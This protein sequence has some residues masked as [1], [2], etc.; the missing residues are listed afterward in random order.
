MVYETLL[1]KKLGFKIIHFIKIFQNDMH[2][3]KPIFKLKNFSWITPSQARVL[4]ANTSLI[5]HYRKLSN[6]E[7][8]GHKNPRFSQI[9]LDNF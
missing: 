8:N 5:F 4:L 2:I 3:I 6:C 1:A 7:R 9:K